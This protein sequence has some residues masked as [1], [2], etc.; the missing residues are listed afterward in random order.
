MIKEIK[1][2]IQRGRRGW[3]DC[4]VWSFDDYLCDI[5]PQGLRKLKGGA[6]C[7][8]EFYDKEA[9]NKECH[10]WNEALEEMAQGFEAA[11]FLKTSGYSKMVHSKEKPGYYTMETDIEAMKNAKEK[12]DKGLQLFAE[13]FLSLWD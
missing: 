8:S 6:G 1:R 2:F 11:A 7:P 13:H 9:K 4:D 3:A 12:M 10:L 5:I